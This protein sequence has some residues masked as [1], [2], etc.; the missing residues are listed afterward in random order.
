MAKAKKK[1]PRKKTAKERAQ[2]RKHIRTVGD[3]RSALDYVGD[4]TEILV[5]GLYSSEASDI[6]A[7]L[8]RKE[9]SCCPT[10]NQDIPERW[11]FVLDTNLCTE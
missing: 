4:E 10:C 2:E 11:R 1:T 9:G 3:L 7:F 5:A 6:V 8:E